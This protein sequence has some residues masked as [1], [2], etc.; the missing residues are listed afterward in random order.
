MMQG[1]FVEKWERQRERGR[2]VYALIHGA[3][4]GGFMA[5]IYAAFKVFEAE[6]PENLT[7][8]TILFFAIGGFAYGLIRF[9]IRERFYRSM[10]GQ[11]DDGS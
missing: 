1:R 2:L 8:Q 9:N 6:A 11:T 10:K 7:P 5:L 3:V 4:I